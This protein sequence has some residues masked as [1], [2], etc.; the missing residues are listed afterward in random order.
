MKSL[1]NKSRSSLVAQW[2]KDP[3]KSLVWLGLLLWLRFNPWSGNFH[4]PQ[5]GKKKKKKGKTKAIIPL[6]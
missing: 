1:K 4:L 3:V 2:V 5:A 6:Y